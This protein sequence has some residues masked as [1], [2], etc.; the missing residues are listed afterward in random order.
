MYPWLALSL[1]LGGADLDLLI[2][3]PQAWS[4]GIRHSPLRLFM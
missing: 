4:A 1:G 3:L 2:P